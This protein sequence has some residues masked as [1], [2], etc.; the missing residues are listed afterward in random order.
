M[1][2]LEALAMHLKKQSWNAAGSVYRILLVLVLMDRWRRNGVPGR[3]CRCRRLGYAEDR[4][5]LAYHLSNGLLGFGTLRLVHASWH[6]SQRLKWLLVLNTQMGGGILCISPQLFS[7]A[8]FCF[9]VQIRIWIL[10][11]ATRITGSVYAVGFCPT[12]LF[13]LQVQKFGLS[14]SS[15]SL[16]FWQTKYYRWLFA[17]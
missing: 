3:S 13:S 11:C 15:L 12:L 9:I 5:L 1:V 16:K 17:I 6:F 14:Y 7:S 8:G 2:L 4:Y 10:Q